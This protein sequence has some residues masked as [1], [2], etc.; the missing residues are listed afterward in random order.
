MRYSF[1]GV[2]LLMLFAGTGLA[3]DV[4]HVV[5]FTD[6]STVIGLIDSLSEDSVYYYDFDTRQKSTLALKKVYYIYNDFNKL[7]YRSPSL[8]SHLDFLEE[9][10]GFVKTVDGRVYPYN[11]IKF[12]RH[13]RDP[14]VY[15]DPT[16][17][18]IRVLNLLDI[19]SVSASHSVMELSVRK[20]FYSSLGLFVLGTTMEILNDFRKNYPRG[21]PVGAALR[22]LGAE[23]WDEGN[24]LLPKA[25]FAGLRETGVTYQSLT[26]FVPLTTVG[27]MV[28]DFIF[29]KRT[30]YIR[31]RERSAKFPRDMYVFSVRRWLKE[32]SRAFYQSFTSPAKKEADNAA[33]QNS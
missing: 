28:Y 9:R 10:S 4:R 1:S 20:G 26:F 5:V 29:D 17:D 33:A 3:E 30:Q 11:R 16:T 13:M 6:G 19:Y 22:L 12:D 8:L 2:L 27:W 25:G 21:Q 7:F 15:L 14:K 18:S 31:P 32:K 23:I 24:D